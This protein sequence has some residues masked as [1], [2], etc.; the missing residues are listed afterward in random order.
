M[1][2][3]GIGDLGQAKVVLDNG[4]LRGGVT[5]DGSFVMYVTSL[6]LLCPTLRTERH[7]SPDVPAGTYVLSVAAHDHVFDQARSC[8]MIMRTLLNVYSVYSYESM[9]SRPR[10]C[11][12]SGRTFQGRLS[13]RPLWLLYHTPSYSRRD[14]G[15]ITSFLANHSIS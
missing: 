4:K 1:E 11:Q 7:P 6:P 10:H 3:A 15:T 12:K 2:S 8:R 5:R 13:P 9:F 14:K